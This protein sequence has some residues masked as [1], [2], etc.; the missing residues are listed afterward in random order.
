MSLLNGHIRVDSCK[1]VNA[2][3]V[4]EPIPSLLA[5][6]MCPRDSS[7]A[8]RVVTICGVLQSRLP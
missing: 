2:A 8:G 3:A 6:V 7:R 4:M 5:L 1:I